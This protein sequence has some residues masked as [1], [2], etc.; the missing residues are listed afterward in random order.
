MFS[1]GGPVS[2]QGPRGAITEGGGTVT[3]TGLSQGADRPRS[4]LPT[5]VA[6]LK[7]II[8]D[9][10][11]HCLSPVVLEGECGSVLVLMAM[12]CSCLESLES[13]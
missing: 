9:C 2:S 4:P 3:G 13:A 6:N 8:Y 1:C 7:I 11:N 10:S 12:G 5:I